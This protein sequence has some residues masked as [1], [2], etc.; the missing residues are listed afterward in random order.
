MKLTSTTLLALL[1]SGIAGVANGQVQVPMN[2]WTYYNHASTVEEGLFRGQAAA[3]QAVGQANYANSLAAVNYADAYRRHIENSRLYVRNAIENREQIR[4]HRIKYSK[5]PMSREALEEYVRKSLPDRLTKDQYKDGKLVWP[6]I[7]RMDAYKAVRDRI[8]ALIAVR[9]PENSG[10]GSPSQ[11]EIHSLVDTAKKLLAD[12][13][14]GMSSS[15]FGDAL[16][17]LNSLDWEMKQPMRLEPAK[18]QG[19]VAGSEKSD[20]LESPKPVAEPK[21]ASQPIAPVE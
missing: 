20:G 11:R 8:D 21:V 1:V 13:I 5:P 2:N 9:T 3:I 7:L 10:D 18:P 19:T 4:E 14:D 15:Q 17:F 6:H 16:W 12:N